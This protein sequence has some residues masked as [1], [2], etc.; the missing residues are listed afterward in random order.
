M[1]EKE[2]ITRFK[3][4]N[5]NTIIFNPDIKAVIQTIQRLNHDLDVEVA[6]DE[7]IS[8]K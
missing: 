6:N 2:G 8:K 4:E 5:G 7:D 1:S 3:Y